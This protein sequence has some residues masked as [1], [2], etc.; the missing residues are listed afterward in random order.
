MLKCCVACKE[1]RKLTRDHIVR[2]AEF[3]WLKEGSWFSREAWQANNIQ[4]ICRPCHDIK[5]RLYT[6]QK[7]AADF[8]GDPKRFSELRMMSRVDL[9]PIEVRFYES[10]SMALDRLEMVR[11]RTS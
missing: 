11:V 3:K 6:E 1:Q 7:I 5:E 8:R 4:R 9:M 10:I 2:R